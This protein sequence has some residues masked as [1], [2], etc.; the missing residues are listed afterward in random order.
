MKTIRELRTEHGLTQLQ[1]ANEI[2]VT[3]SAVVKWEAGSTIPN[4]VQLRSLARRFDVR[5]EDIAL[6]GIDV[7][8]AG[9]P[10]EGKAAA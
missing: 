5:I 9:N 8:R 7:D 10:L 3:P 2:R 1:L 4:I 6:V